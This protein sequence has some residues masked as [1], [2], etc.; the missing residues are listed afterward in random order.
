MEIKNKINE[1]VKFYPRDSNLGS[2]AQTFVL[3][4]KSYM[5]KISKNNVA[6]LDQIKILS[7]IQ[8]T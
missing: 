6:Y 8:D 1:N 2:I 4:H 7:Y 5:N 3:I